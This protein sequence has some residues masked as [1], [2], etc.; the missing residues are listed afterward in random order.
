[1]AGMALCG[2][3][4]VFFT[5]VLRRDIHKVILP[6][7]WMLRF[8]CAQDSLLCPVFVSRSRACPHVI[9]PRCRFAGQ[10]VGPIH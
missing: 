10:H 9:M 5:L 8:L 6:W 3:S 7:G 2:D 1:M 4:G